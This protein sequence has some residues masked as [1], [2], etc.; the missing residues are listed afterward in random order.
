MGKKDR[1]GSKRQSIN[2]TQQSDD[3]VVVNVAEQY[4]WLTNQVED[5]ASKRKRGNAKYDAV[6]VCV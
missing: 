6:D 4:E 3:E 2:D 1:K 5:E